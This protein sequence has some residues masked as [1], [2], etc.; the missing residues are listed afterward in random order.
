MSR[1]SP[2]RSPGRQDDADESGTAGRRS[3][4]RRTRPTMDSAR[5]TGFSW[6]YAVAAQQPRCLRATCGLCSP[7]YA[8]KAP[9]PPEESARI[10]TCY[11]NVLSGRGP[12]GGVCR[13]HGISFREMTQTLPDGSVR[14]VY[15]EAD[16]PTVSV[17]GFARVGR[18]PVPCPH[19]PR[20]SMPAVM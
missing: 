14:D 2:R 1:R 9:F 18:Y 3:S 5:S 4:P 15:R 8:S 11:L 16:S 20:Q 12:A 17:V 19:V 6:H 7:T 10:E 13:H